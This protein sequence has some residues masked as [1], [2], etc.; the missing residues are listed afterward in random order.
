MDYAKPADVMRTMIDSA[1]NKLALAPRDLLSHLR[2]IENAEGRL[3][4]VR[5]ASRTLDLDIVA[6]DRQTISD[7]DLQVPH[8]ELPNRAFWQR[9]LAELRGGE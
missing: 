8:A 6:F 5:W 2:S 1:G 9:E 3:R 4:H 7:P